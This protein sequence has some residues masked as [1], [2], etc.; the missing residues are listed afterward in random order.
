M[1]SLV[2]FFDRSYII[3]LADRADRR[4]QAEKEFGRVGIAMPNDKVGFYTATRP[5]DK[6]NFTDVGTRGC[7]E[8]HRN[9]LEL[10]HR[11]GLKNVLIFEDDVCF[12]NISE[13]FERKLI[14]LISSEAWELIYFGYGYPGDEALTG[15]LLKWTGDIQGSHFYAV[16]GQFI[17]PMLDYMRKCESRPRDHP[18]GGP[19]PADGI[20]NHV[21]YVFPDV[22]LFLSVPNLAHQRS[23]R[24]DIAE[25]PLYDGMSWLRP[26]VDGIRATK[27]RLRMA[28]DRKIIA[29]R[30]EK[31]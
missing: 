1:K 21:R 5:S 26:I 4:R 28:R 12:R 31:Y 22:R 14:S 30:M 20:T 13:S 25:M 16:N 23:S 6:G 19:M 10:A 8:S 24:T 11:D 18:E 17:G 15:P 2:E 3:N 7:F 27:Q 9:V 29:R